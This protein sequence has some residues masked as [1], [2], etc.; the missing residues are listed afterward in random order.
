[1]NSASP[2]G[3]VVVP[4]FSTDVARYEETITRMSDFLQELAVRV[5]AMSADTEQAMTGLRM[6]AVKSGQSMSVGHMVHVENGAAAKAIAS[7]LTLFATDMVWSMVG[8]S[9]AMVAPVGYASRIMVKGGR[10]SRAAQRL[11]LSPTLAGFVTTT[12]PTTDDG[13]L[14]QQVVGLTKSVSPQ[15]AW[16]D[17]RPSEVIEL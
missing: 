17:I 14:Y 3:V 1:M 6:V 4:S 9:R 8:G 16:I 13:A 10:W 5:N 11:F 15:E 7:D 12:P 2:Y